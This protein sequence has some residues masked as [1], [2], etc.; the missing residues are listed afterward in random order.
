MRTRFTAEELAYLAGLPDLPR[1]VPCCDL[2][3][4]SSVPNG[5]LGFVEACP[6]PGCKQKRSVC[7]DCASPVRIHVHG[8]WAYFR[9]GELIAAVPAS[10][11]T[12][13]FA[14]LDDAVAVYDWLDAYHAS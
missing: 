8:G 6:E 2:S 10:G 13:R 14:S 12:W 1:C 5:Y 4:D 3:I 9:H 7:L 11:D